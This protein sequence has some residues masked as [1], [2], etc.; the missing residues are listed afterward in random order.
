MLKRFYSKRSGFTLAEIIVAFAVFAIMA[1]MIAQ[2]LNLAVTARLYNN[3]YARSLSSQEKVLTIVK[4]SSE[5]YDASGASGTLNFDF[6]GVTLPAIAYQTKSAADPRE[7]TSAEGL[8]YFLSPVDYGDEGETPPAAAGGGAG[9]GSQMSRMDTR[10]TGT[11]N[12]KN[13]KIWRIVKDTHTQS[14]D[15]SQPNYLEDGRTRYLVQVSASADETEGF[16]DEDVP[17]AQYRLYFYSDKLDAAASSVVKTDE[18]GR[19]YTE[20]VY[21]AAKILK[22]G[23]LKDTVKNVMD[24]GLNASNVASG[25]DNNFNVYTVEQSGSNGVRIGTPF[26]ENDS[27]GVSIGYGSNK[28]VRFVSSSYSNFYVEFDGDPNLTPS[29]FGYNGEADSSPEGSMLYSACP[30]YIDLYEDDGTPQYYSEGNHV[31]IYG[32]YLYKRNYT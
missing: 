30:N 19:S 6:D 11:R 15:P 13:I 8:N 14:T 24:T 20:E 25:I 21:E 12:F 29:S 3:E 7:L 22:V 26:K 31:N 17:Y 18:D 1:G 16:Q 23:Y 32:A 5:N 27:R 28:G 2:I 4:K 10:I 9:A